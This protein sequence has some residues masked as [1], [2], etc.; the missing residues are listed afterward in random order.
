M[1]LLTKLRSMLGGRG[2]GTEK[3]YWQAWDAKVGE[4]ERRI[5]I[6]QEVRL[7]D[8][9]LPAF[10]ADCASL[11]ESLS[12]HQEGEDRP[13]HVDAMGRRLELARRAARVIRS[14]QADRDQLWSDFLE[15]L[16]QHR[17]VLHYKTRVRY[18]RLRLDHESG[19]V[20]P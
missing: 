19:R 2:K 16:K 14:N 8:G 17:N 15:A 12:G 4:L 10:E 18:D 1:A 20:I 5:R 9:G 13:T 6:N 11:L 7:V 3:E